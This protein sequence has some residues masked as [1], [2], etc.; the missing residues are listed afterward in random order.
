M[1]SK[2]KAMERYE[3]VRALG[4]ECCVLLKSDG[5][6]PCSVDKIALFGNGARHTS[7]GGTG[8]GIVNV[9]IFT[10]IE[11]GLK[12]AGI[13]MTSRCWLDAYDEMLAKAKAEYYKKSQGILAVKGFA[14]LGEINGSKF[15][16]PEY[17]LPIEG[18]GDTAVYVASRLSG[19]GVDRTPTKGDIFL[20]DAEVR[21]IRL[22]A[23]RYQRMVLVLNVSGFVDL[24]PVLEET[25]NILLISQ[26]GVAT[27]DILADILTGKAYPCGKL[28]ST[29]ARYEDYPAI[30]DFGGH[31]DTHYKEGIYVGYRYFDTVE[32]KPMFPFGFG[33]SYTTFEVR[34]T[35]LTVD[36]SYVSVHVSVQNTG[37]RAGKE[38][39]QVYVSVP[40]DKLSQPFQTLA[41]FQKTKE[42]EAA[43]EHEL[44][45]TF[46]LRELRSFD[47]QTGERVLE[48]GDYIVR[49]GNSSQNTAPAG[50]IRLT[51]RVAVE[52]VHHVGGE[53]TFKDWKP[54]SKPDVTAG[55]EDLAVIIMDRPAI[56][57][58]QHTRPAPNA[59][60]RRL[61]ESMSNE[62]LAILCN[63]GYVNE[64]IENPTY[65]HGIRVAGEVGLTTG[66]LTHRGIPPL[67]LAD[68]PAG[69]HING[70][71]RED[72]F[73]VYPLE[74]PQNLEFK[75]LV[76]EQLYELVKKGY[77]QYQN[78]GRNGQLKYQYCTAIP[79]GM[80][81][82]QSWNPDVSQQCGDIVGEELDQYGVHVWL[83]PGMNIHRSILCGRNFEYFSEDPL[84]AGR[85]GCGI[86][87]GAQKHKGHACT[88]KHFC[89]NNQEYNR[90][91]SNSIVSE[92]ALRDIYA[93]PFEIVIKE[94]KPLGLMSS[95]NL[96]N[97][98][99]TCQRADLMETV[100]RDEWG[101][102]GIVMTDW[103]G[104]APEDSANKWPRF[105]ANGVIKAG[106]DIMMP[107][108]K[109]DFDVLMNAIDNPDAEYPITRENLVK[110]ASRLIE[111]IW[112]L[113]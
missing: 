54:E 98:E 22:C 4:A 109:K 16:E 107:G 67:S 47:E 64:G 86:V 70:E 65:P 78:D 41:A 26:L 113:I 73:G 48:H 89:C 61:A 9:G 25:P 19:E 82:A 23:K 45:I 99:H 8:G 18:E 13:E 31:D 110:C 39:V 85:M 66:Q 87:Q 97:G 15:D 10:T 37:K 57:P 106:N 68:G 51:E 52:K 1:Y 46:D 62:E 83:A 60:A 29:C 79:I 96:V 33:L 101:F 91:N 24:S 17:M 32:K 30:G 94:A 36:G 92:R 55:G 58:I 88:P 72:E 111:Y 63:G 103:L 40:E 20:T 84:L 81:L 77:P 95:Y 7:M 74:T 105:H 2:E 102:E 38:T 80:A 6:F 43:Q 112:K 69:L 71:Y 11:E 28:A 34:P 108:S 104:D 14:G 56:M 93:R 59:D 27:G 3:R 49:V 53:C 44:T 75:E 5:S 12:K 42:I 50:I 100:L 76:G 90:T 21:D 35:R